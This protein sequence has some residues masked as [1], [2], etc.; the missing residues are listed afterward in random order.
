MATAVV[1]I[2][3]RFTSRQISG[4]L[5]FDFSSIKY[6][7][8]VFLR[9]IKLNETNFILSDIKIIVK[10]SVSIFFLTESVKNNFV[11]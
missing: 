3:Y 2:K 5:K 6:N 4:E 7:F 11:F 8:S 9:D 10:K 1:K